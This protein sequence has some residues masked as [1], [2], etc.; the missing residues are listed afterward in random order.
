MAFVCFWRYRRDCRIDKLIIERQE[1]E[2][3]AFVRRRKVTYEGFVRVEEGD[4]A[5]K[6]AEKPPIGFRQ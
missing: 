4:E 1:R 3:E 6:P 5:S 2:L